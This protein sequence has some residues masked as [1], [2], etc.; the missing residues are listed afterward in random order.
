[1]GEFSCLPLIAVC[2]VRSNP[3]IRFVLV[4]VFLDALG[5][6]LIIPVLPRLIG[7][8]AGERNLQAY[9]YGII[10]VSYGLMQFLSSPVLGALSDRYGRKPVLLTGIFGLG[11][12][13][14]VPAIASSLPA[15]LAS[16]LAGGTLS[17]NIVVAQ[18]YIADITAPSK[19]AAAFGKI[20][21]VFG[22][23]FVIGP[24]IGGILGQVNPRIPFAFATVICMLNFL[25]G[26]LALPES[27]HETDPRPWSLSRFN[28]FS[29]FMTLLHAR[30]IVPLVAV[31][32]LIYLAQSLMQCTWALYTE[33]RYEWTPLD[34]GLSMFL[35]GLCIAAA[36]G[37]LLPRLLKRTNEKAL[38]LSALAAG[39]LSLVGIGLSP[40]GAIAAFLSW[41]F[42]FTG[43]A[44]AVIQGIIS[45]SVSK[46]SQGEVMGAV[47]SLNSFSGAI[48]P[49]IS[50]PLLVYTASSDPNSLSA[51]VPYLLSGSV[52]CLGLLIAISFAIRLTRIKRG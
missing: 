20:G 50:T 35:L 49:V 51:G 47:S 6:G 19:R 15:I 16:R 2:M 32:G 36:Q 22:I 21:A 31:I 12:M 23:A 5:F 42:A 4:C 9:W 41:T 11:I 48:A 10:M 40:W 3:A 45:R 44:S 43:M 37:W 7:E 46:T 29:G 38:V 13:Q 14:L 25:Y 24:A 52:L 27:L 18:A 28:P 1:M 34:I 33:F 8:L 39:S 17:A 26:L 30:V